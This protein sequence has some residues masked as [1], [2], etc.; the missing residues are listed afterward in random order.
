MSQRVARRVQ[1]RQVVGQGR[2]RTAQP[3]LQPPDLHRAPLDLSRATY[4]NVAEAV[5]YLR[6]TDAKNPKRALYE[7][8]RRNQIPK[9][10][11]GRTGRL[12][13]LRRDLDEARR[14]E[15]GR[16][17]VRHSKGASQING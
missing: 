9:C 5:D 3:K 7:W 14:P 2:R 16:K 8:A 12:L 10:R 4:L 13:F 15:E 11:P 1:R 6:F 17:Q